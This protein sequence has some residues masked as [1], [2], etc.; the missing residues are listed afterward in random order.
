MCII[1]N[2]HFVLPA[3]CN[4]QGVDTLVPGSFLEISKRRKS[5]INSPIFRRFIA[6][7]YKQVRHPVTRG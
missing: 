5:F 6:K 1:L 3:I 2:L 7:I 4:G